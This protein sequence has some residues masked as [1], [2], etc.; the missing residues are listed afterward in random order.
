MPRVRA[1]FATRFVSL[2]LAV[3][4]TSASELCASK[5]TPPR[6]PSRSPAPL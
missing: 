4:L 6:L 5:P 3:L 1:G 2:I